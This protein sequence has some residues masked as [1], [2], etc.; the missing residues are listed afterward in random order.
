SGRKSQLNWA[1]APHLEFSYGSLLLGGAATG[2]GG[3]GPANVSLTR[4]GTGIVLEWEGG[5][6]LQTA[7]AV[8]GPWSEVSGASSGVQIEVSGREAYY[9][10]R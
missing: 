3:G 8:T 7:P 4:S 9:R 10:V 5:G 1:G 6:S 2:G